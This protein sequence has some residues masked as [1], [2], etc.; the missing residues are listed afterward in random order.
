MGGRPTGR[1]E[2]RHQRSRQ[3]ERCQRIT[4]SGGYDGDGREKRGDQLDRGRDGEPITSLEA[5]M[6]GSSPN[7]DELLAEKG[8]LGEQSGARA[9]HRK[10]RREKAGDKFMDHCGRV[11]AG[12]GR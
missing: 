3:N 11:S 1:R 12:A 10:Q 8:V 4:V 9:K 2:R 6:R 5:G 7:D